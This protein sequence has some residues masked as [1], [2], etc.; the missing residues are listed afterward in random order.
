MLCCEGNG[1]DAGAAADVD[2]A[3]FGRLGDWSAVEAMMLGKPHAMLQICE[4][5]SRVHRKVRA[6]DKYTQAASLSLDIELA[7]FAHST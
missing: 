6:D 3:L 7:V 4:V 2:D 1:P 5:V